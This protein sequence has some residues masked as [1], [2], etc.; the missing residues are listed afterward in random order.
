M[1]FGKDFVDMH[2]KTRLLP[3]A[4]LGLLGLTAC[5]GSTPINPTLLADGQLVVGVLTT[6]DNVAGNVPG[7]PASVTGLVGLALV[8]IK[9]GLTALQAGTQTPA[10]V[11]SLIQ[12]EIATVAQPVAVDLKANATITNGLAVLSNLVP[13]IA[14]DVTPAPV[15]GTAAA[16][17]PTP[18]PDPRQA[19]LNW[20]AAPTAK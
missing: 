7:V 5:P 3:A 13:V 17:G 12:T 11:A 2:T 4:L 9:D 8:G 20:A 19:A 14:A 18:G 1:P 15:G 10:A 6:L 16:A